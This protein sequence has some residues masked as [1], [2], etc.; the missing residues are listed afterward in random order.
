M[1]KELSWFY[2]P[3]AWNGL[4]HIFGKQLIKNRVVVVFW[5]L[6]LVLKRCGPM[7]WG[8]CLWPSA[9]RPAIIAGLSAPVSDCPTLV[10]GPSGVRRTCD[11]DRVSDRACPLSPPVFLLSGTFRVTTLRDILGVQGSPMTII[12]LLLSATQGRTMTFFARRL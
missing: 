12:Y 8:C 2:W 6:T 10:P 1:H 11:R 5:F 3:V 9:D 4:L 7:V